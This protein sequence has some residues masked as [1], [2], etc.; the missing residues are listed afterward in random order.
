M[1]LQNCAGLPTVRNPR[2][3][4]YNHY[5]QVQIEVFCCFNSNKIR[6]DKI[7]RQLE[8]KPGERGKDGHSKNF[9]SLQFYDLG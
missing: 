8:S 9:T 3:G 6:R 7:L 1:V 4:I 2:S 5:F